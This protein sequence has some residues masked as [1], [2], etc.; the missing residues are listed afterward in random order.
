M[1]NG[2]KGRLKVKKI[3]YS[4]RRPDMLAKDILSRLRRSTI[5]R[6]AGRGRG[7]GSGWVDWLAVGF[8][9]ASDRSAI[10]M[11]GAGAEWSGLQ[12]MAGMFRAWMS[13]TSG[14]GLKDLEDKKGTML[15]NLGP[16]KDVQQR[17]VAGVSQRD[18]LRSSQ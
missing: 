13:G 5:R 15:S 16:L 10:D 7:A 3:F 17:R 6:V 11:T 8:D 12:P 9:A 4:T 1:I 2:R 14:A 18:T